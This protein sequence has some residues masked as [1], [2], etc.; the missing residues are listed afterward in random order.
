M[1]LSSLIALETLNLRCGTVS[2]DHIES[3]YCVTVLV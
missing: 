3:I 1:A 2:K